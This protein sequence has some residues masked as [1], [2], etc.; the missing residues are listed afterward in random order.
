MAKG[1]NYRVAFRR[2][3]EARTD[4]RLRRKLII[5]GSLRLVVRKSLKHINLQLVEAKFEGDSVLAH[6]GTIE[7]KKFG[8]KVG[9]GN[10]PASYLAGFLL[11]KRAIAMD[12][13]TAIA[14]F[15][16]YKITASNK[17]Y[18]ALKGAI[19]AG[20]GVPHD[21]KVI[22]DD[23]RVSGAHIAKYADEMQKADPAKYQAYF[24]QY[25][26]GGIAPEKLAEHFEATKKRIE[27]EVK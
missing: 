17:L 25:L 15:N 1:T 16:S 23:D 13:N 5:S 19:D 22:P 9:T 6:A 8:W 27:K 10:L 2:R 3:R 20:L 11:G 24:S 14:D 21:E 4:Y 7:L 26:A 12:K 18:A